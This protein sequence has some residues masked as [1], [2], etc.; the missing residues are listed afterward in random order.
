MTNEAPS[1]AG[2]T[3]ADSLKFQVNAEDHHLRVDRFLA[4]RCEDLSRNMVQQAIRNGDVTVDGQKVPPRY[5][6]K[7]GQIVCMTRKLK[8]GVKEEH[9]SLPAAPE[10]ALN[11]CFR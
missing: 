10:I 8:T 2:D 11:I 5:R 1:P 9:A 4:E 6:L 7:P 3:A